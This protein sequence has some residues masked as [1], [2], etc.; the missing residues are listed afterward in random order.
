SLLNVLSYH[1]IPFCFKIQQFAQLLYCKF[2]SGTCQFMP[3]RFTVYIEMGNKG[4]ISLEVFIL[5]NPYLCPNWKTNHSRFN[6]IE[7]VAKPVKID[8]QTGEVIESYTNA[9]AT[10]CRKT[11]EGPR[12]R[13][14]CA[15]CGPVEVEENFIK[16]ATYTPK[17]AH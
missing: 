6:I 1:F 16:Y 15:S 7:Q 3:D 8:P 2:V 11:Y 12:Y 17:N 9:A 13:V 14:Q 4:I 5:P 10:I